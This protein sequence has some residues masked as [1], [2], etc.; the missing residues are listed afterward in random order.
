M[1]NTLSF[2]HKLL[3][4]GISL[5]IIPLVIAFGFVFNQNEKNTSL[6]RSESIKMADADLQHTVESIYTLARTQQEVI[7]KNLESALNVATDLLVKAGGPQFSQENQQWDVTNQS[8]KETSSVTLPKMY[9]GET[10]LGQISDK[11]QNAPLVDEVL[12]LVG[13]TCTVF[14]VM[15]QSGDMLRV[16]T[17]VIKENGQR[18]IGTYIPSQ[19]TDGSDNPVISAVKRGET[20]L[21]RAYVVNGWYITAYKPIY[22]SSNTLVGMLYVGIPQE[23]TTTLR[24]VVMDMIIGKTGYVYVLDKKGTY[25]ISK[26]GEQDGHNIMDS[27][28]ENGQ[29]FIKALIAKAVTLNGSETADQT[30]QWKDTSDGIVKTKKVKIAYFKKWDWVIGAGSFEDEFIESAILIAEGARRGNIS[31]LI[32]IGVSIA[33]AVMVWIIVARGVMKQLGDDPSEIARIADSIAKGDLTVEFNTTGKGITGVYGNMKNMAE[34]LNHMFTDIQGG[35]QTLTSSSTEL[36]AISEQM[37]SGSAQSSQQATHVA[38]AAE[39]MSTS[40]NSVAAATEQTTA[41]LQMIVAA[42]EEMSVTRRIIPSSKNSDR[43][44]CL[45]ACASAGGVRCA[46]G[47]E[48]AAGVGAGV[49]AWVG[50]GIR[51]GI[52]AGIDAGVGA[53]VRA[54]S[55]YVLLVR[56]GVETGVGAS[57]SSADLGTGIGIGVHTRLVSAIEVVVRP[58]IAEGV[59]AGI[60]AWVVTIDQGVGTGT[61]L[62]M[63]VLNKFIQLP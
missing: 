60:E 55:T 22:D 21:G 16:A 1:Q 42:A 12:T 32:L 4:I 52:D 29:Y 19:N 5:T 24:K 31:L 8:T 7:E 62:D 40:M 57:A 50:A 17:N 61:G 28:D 34:N 30:Y 48:V 54:K 45:R 2:K 39:E 18:A 6:A 44:P 13:T 43:T 59:D 47:G 10:W 20:Y 3:F 63:L 23:S 38:A 11:N 41:N 15:N 9:V 14:Q 53:G 33:A 36:S 27:T 26:N 35:V 25:L 49:G 46:V 51:A 58:G 37:A 56:A